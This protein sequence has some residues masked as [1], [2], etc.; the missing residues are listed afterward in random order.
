MRHSGGAAP[1]LY[2]EGRPISVVQCSLACQQPEGERPVVCSGEFAVQERGIQCSVGRVM[3]S[4]IN[5]LEARGHV[6]PL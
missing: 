4:G 1:T 3:C 6:L 2:R 5:G